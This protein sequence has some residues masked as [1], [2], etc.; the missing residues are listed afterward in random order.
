MPKPL[1]MYVQRGCLFSDEAIAWLSARGIPFVERD[2]RRDPDVLHDLERLDTIVTPT[3]FVGDEVIYGF[4][5][6]C[7]AGLLE[8]RDA[9]AGSRDATA[10]GQTPA[11]G[12]GSG[13]PPG[14]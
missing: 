2:I 10:A 7:L 12:H 14:K 1:T 3:I 11:A 6:D 5:V 13:P 8:G 9:M 4:D